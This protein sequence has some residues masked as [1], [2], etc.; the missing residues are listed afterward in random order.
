MLIMK[1]MV[2]CPTCRKKAPWEGNPWR[3]FCGER[4][5]T[6]DL[7]RWADN[8][9]AIPAEPAEDTAAAAEPPAPDPRQEDTDGV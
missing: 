7:G 8:R 1:R 6:T 5:A 9:Y 4:C 2:C 3:P